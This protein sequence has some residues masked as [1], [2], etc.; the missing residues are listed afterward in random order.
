MLIHMVKNA[1]LW[2]NAFPA[3]DGISTQHSPR[4][5][6]TGYELTFDKHAILEFGSYVQTHEEHTND[7]SHHTLGAVCLGPTGNRQ[8]GHW[9]MSLSSGG[10]ITRHRWTTLPMPQE[11]IEQVNQIGLNQGMPST[12]TYAD[13]QGQELQDALHEIEDDD[14]TYSDDTSSADEQLDNDS[15]GS[16]YSYDS[17][18][19][20]DYQSQV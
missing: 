20:I 13:R 19:D 4:Y 9:F 16:G 14:S 3:S 6:L 8:G 18:P 15:L 17:D 2:F 7:M 10:R 11:A 12:I 5:F 1:A